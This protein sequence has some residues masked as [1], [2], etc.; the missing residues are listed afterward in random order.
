MCYIDPRLDSTS[1][2]SGCTNQWKPIT[3][4][5]RFIY[6]I[7]GGRV[8]QKKSLLIVLGACSN[9]YKERNAAYQHITVYTKKE[10]LFLIDTL[11]ACKLLLHG[12]HNSVFGTVRSV[13]EWRFDKIVCIQQ[14]VIIASITNATSNKS[15]QLQL[16]CGIRDWLISIR[17]IIFAWLKC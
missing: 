3:S 17:W 13:C 9:A 11:P 10:N 1:V 5:I 15:N 6:F 12:R 2:H 7:D 16:T 4:S 14:M 8:K